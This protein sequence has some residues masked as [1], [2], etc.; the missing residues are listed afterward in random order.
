MHSVHVALVGQ[1]DG[2]SRHLQPGVRRRQVGPQSFE[3]P[4]PAGHQ[5]QGPRPGGKLSGELTADTR[6]SAG[7]QHSAAIE[8]RTYCHDA[9]LLECE[10]IR[11]GCLGRHAHWARHHGQVCCLPGLMA[12]GQK[13][14]TAQISRHAAHVTSRPSPS[15]LPSRRD[16]RREETTTDIKTTA[17]AQLAAGGP[18]AISLRAIARQLGMTPSAVHYYF[19]GREA[20]IDALTVDG[21][22]SLATALRARYEQAR[23]LPKRTS[24]GS[25]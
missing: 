17:R 2:N 8:R 12:S 16:R 20:L 11:P 18:T 6:R 5:D 22:D 7:Y 13:L 1:V 14:D 25:P 24:G 3:Q 10:R 9:V 15:A 4:G 23:P 21:W 19:P